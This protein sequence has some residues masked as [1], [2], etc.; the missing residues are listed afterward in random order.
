M[1]HTK[2]Q[3]SVLAATAVF[4]LLWIL[5]SVWQCLI[6][7]TLKFSTDAMMIL[8]SVVVKGVLWAAIPLALLKFHD[9]GLVP[10]RQL[11]SGEFPW[12]PCLVAVTLSAAFLHK[13]GR[14]HV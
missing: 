14:A 13:I 12:L 4:L 9:R 5:W 2:K 1:M 11:F 7:P 10:F 3:F 8:D 6:L